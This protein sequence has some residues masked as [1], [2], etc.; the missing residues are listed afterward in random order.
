MRPQVGVGVVVLDGEQVLLIKRGKPPRMG[1]W[2][3]PGGR[4]EFGETLHAAA[5]RETAEE[6]GLA[7]T[8]K[9]IVDIVEMIDHNAE[10]TI[11]YHYILID[12]WAVV[13][14]GKLCAGDDAADAAWYDIKDIANLNMW[15]E[16]QKV[17]HKAMLMRDINET[18]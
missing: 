16:T 13:S 5:I 8:P 3:L 2:S 15:G 17:I 11:H 7:I 18:L 6:T 10:N 4:L 12:Y 9:A 14:G 1:E